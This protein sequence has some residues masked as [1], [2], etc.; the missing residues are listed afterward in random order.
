MMFDLDLANAVFAGC[1]LVGGGL[2]LV[3]VL[4]DDILGGVLDFLSVDFD[5]GGVSLMPLLLGFVS[6][7]GVGGLVGTQILGLGSGPATGIGV[8]FG[9][10]GAGIVYA[11]F[12]FLRRAEAPEAF[13]L[14]DLVG[15]DAR[16]TVAIPARRYGTVF[17]S[18]AGESHQLTATA[19][20]DLPAGSTVRIVSVAGSNLIVESRRA[21]APAAT[22]EGTTNAS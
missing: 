18:H 10:L 21:E 2:L 9:F 3:T 13:S 20:T 11:M 12:G 1:V 6:M 4:L 16:V 14:E 15:K 22:P 19:D 8:G 17:L 5:L 7:F